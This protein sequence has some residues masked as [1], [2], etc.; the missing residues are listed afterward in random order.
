MVF[1]CF[2]QNWPKRLISWV[3]T[4]A[5]ILVHNLVKWNINILYETSIIWLLPLNYIFFAIYSFRIYVQKSSFF[6][7]LCA[8]V[9]QYGSRDGVGF[10]HPDPTAAIL[11]W[12]WDDRTIW[13]ML[14]MDRCG[15]AV[16]SG[17]LAFYVMSWLV[18]RRTLMSC[19]LWHEK[20][21]IWKDVYVLGVGCDA[22]F[23]AFVILLSIFIAQKGIR[24][25]NFP[26]HYSTLL[27]LADKDFVG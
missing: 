2:I 15:D 16:I 10:E 24:L 14:Q 8:Q 19:H 5:L 4:S 6:L 20:C 27:S 17:W 13:V 23:R 21:A 9:I 11:L 7:I 22:L 25:I 18:S 1:C 3:T 26:E 12:Q